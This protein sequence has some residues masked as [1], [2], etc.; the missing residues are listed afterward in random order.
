MRGLPLE[1]HRSAVIKGVVGHLQFK[2]VDTIIVDIDQ[3]SLEAIRSDTDFDKNSGL[4]RICERGSTGKGTRS[5]GYRIK[6]KSFPEVGILLDVT[7]DKV[8]PWG[9][10]W[11]S[12][13]FVAANISFH[14]DGINL[15]L[16]V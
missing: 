14:L 8:L 9:F 15:H 12:E 1:S 16:D 11:H 6:R 13:L 3:F 5:S 7:H 4:N 2:V 10:E